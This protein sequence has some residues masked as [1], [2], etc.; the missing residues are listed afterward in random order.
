MIRPFP[1][2]VK[3][4]A[5]LALLALAGCAFPGAQNDVQR[6]AA[7]DCGSEANRIY[8]AQN[9]TQLSE[10][11]TTDTPFSAGGPPPGPS[12]GLSD[13]YGY[14]QLVADCLKRSEAVPAAGDTH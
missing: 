6:E 4:L 1:P 2:L 13:R 9:R 11:D 3:P 7:Q 12:A 8:N 5:A 14:D 10:R